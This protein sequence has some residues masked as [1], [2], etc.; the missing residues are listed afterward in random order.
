MSEFNPIVKYLDK[1]EEVD[2]IVPE[3]IREACKL[4]MLSY[5]EVARQCEIKT[6]EFGLIANG[7]I[8]APKDYIFKFMKVF[9]LPKNF[10][11]QIKWQ[12][13]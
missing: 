1:I 11:Y 7:Y 3:R 4:R 8:P 6:R 5:E 2:Y 12:R 9:N 10:F 13:V